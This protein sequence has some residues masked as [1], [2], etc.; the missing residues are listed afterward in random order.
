MSTKKV[1]TLTLERGDSIDSLEERGYSQEVRDQIGYHVSEM[2]CSQIFEL[3]VVHADPNH[4]NFAFRPD[5]KIVIYDFGCVKY[6]SRDFIER[7]RR[8]VK[9]ALD[10]DFETFDQGLISLGARNPDGPPIEPEYYR[11]WR[12]I[13]MRPF[14]EF[15]DYGT[16]TIHEEVVKR[17]PGLLKRLSSFRP[18]AELFFLDRMIVGHYE[19]MRKLRARGYYGD[20]LRE[21]LEKE[22]LSDRE[23]ESL[24]EGKEKIDSEPN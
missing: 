2:V 3:G 13:I 16:S 10:E 15:F 18:S 22:P 19:T 6:L 20:M 9:A 14:L 21:Y 7:Y 12:S 5:G 1:L 23:L 4:A 24:I 17:I 8:T 11:E